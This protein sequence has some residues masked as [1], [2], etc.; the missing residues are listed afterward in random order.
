[1]DLVL[2]LGVL[3]ARRT[4]SA[5][6]HGRRRRRGAMGIGIHGRR[7]GQAVPAGKSAAGID[8]PRAM[9]V[10][11]RRIFFAEEME[12]PSGVLSY[13]IGLW[14]HE[15]DDGRYLDRCQALFRPQ[16]LAGATLRRCGVAIQLERTARRIY[17]R[18]GI[19]RTIGCGSAN[20]S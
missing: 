13:D 7:D 10:G 15:P 4:A 2:P 9:A 18:L 1:M 8:G 12:Y 20:G 6:L 3:P 17:V 5:I 14:A 19:S 16:R 11:A